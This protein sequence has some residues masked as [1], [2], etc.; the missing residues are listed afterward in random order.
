MSIKGK[1]AAAAA[2]PAPVLEVTNLDNSAQVPDSQLWSALGELSIAQPANVIVDATGPSGAT[3]TYPLPA[4]GDS[5]SSTPPAA[6]CKPASGRTFKIGTTTVT[7]TATDANDLNSPLST[8]FTVTVEGAPA[9]LA[10]LHQAVQAYGVYNILALA[11]STAQHAVAA[12]NTRLACQ[13]L[14]GFID[15]AGLQLPAAEAR[16]LITDAKRIEAVLAC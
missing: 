1:I 8:S 15:D 9:Q 5:G 7:C 12:G 11:V 3:V 13:S 16:P 6:V 4:V 10:S 2:A 14:N